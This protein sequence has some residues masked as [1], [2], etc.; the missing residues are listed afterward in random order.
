M[1]TEQ[2]RVVVLRRKHAPF[3]F[4]RASQLKQVDIA[5]IFCE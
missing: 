3:V 2:G 1:M 5:C 4:D